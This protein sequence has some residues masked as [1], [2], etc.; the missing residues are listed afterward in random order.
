M[1]APEAIEF[2]GCPCATAELTGSH[3]THH[4]LH[5]GADQLKQC[6]FL[7]FICTSKFPSLPSPC[8]GLQFIKSA[9]TM[10]GGKWRSE[11]AGQLP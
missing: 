8:L 7:E 6:I 4:M 10:G 9:L 2:G 3:A 11:H 1:L 5:C